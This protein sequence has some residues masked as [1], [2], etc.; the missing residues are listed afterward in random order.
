LKATVLLKWTL[1][2][3]EARHRDPM[4]EHRDGFKT[5]ELAIQIWN[6]V[7]GDAFTY[8]ASAVIQ[9]QTRRGKRP[10]S[11]FLHSITPLLE[12]EQT[13][14]LLP[15]DIKLTVLQAFETLVRSLI[16]HASSEL[17]KI[18]QRQEDLVLASARSDRTRVFRSSTPATHHRFSSTA[19]TDAERTSHTSPR[20]DIATLY[21]FIGLLYSSLPDERAIQFWGSGP[22]VQSHRVTYLEYVEATAGKL[23]AFLQWAVWSSQIGDVDMLMALYDMLSGLAKGRQ[24]SELAYNFVA[25]G[26]GEVIS[27]STLPS[28]N[29]SHY[30]SRPTVSWGV[31]FGLLDSWVSSTV[32]V[33][34]SQA[35]QSMGLNSSQ[36]WQTPGLA[37][38]N[39]PQQAPTLGPKDVLLAQSFLRF[40]ST[41][42]TYSTAVRLAI[43]GH[44]QFRAIPTLVSLIP[45]AIPLEL[46]GA[47]FAVWRSAKLYGPSWRSLRSSTSVLEPM[48]SLALDQT[49]YPPRRVSRWN[50]KKLRQPTRCTLPQYHS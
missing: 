19:T 44:A 13:R 32:N 36:S 30:P 31:I 34:T 15:E 47:L 48:V 50:W 20:N 41:V 43:S 7:Q 23:P 26:A 42:V 28:S 5:E 2:L 38:N 27:G 17:R 24:C 37:V 49:C 22:Q 11:S 16:I 45:L 14:D 46:K 18:K 9:L 25:R 35:Q 4:L 10:S 39:P 3:T 29:S 21:S 40:L 6:A 33:R 12:Q 1:F 8:L